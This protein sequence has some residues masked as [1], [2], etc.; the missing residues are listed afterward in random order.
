VKPNSN[1]QPQSSDTG[2]V[3]FWQ[4]VPV[5][6]RAIVLGFVVFESGVFVWAAIL[7]PLLPTP[8]SVLAMGGV[9]WVYW[10]YLSGSWWPETTREIR[11]KRFRAIKMPGLVWKWGLVAAAL[12]VVVVQA[13]FV[14]TFRLVEFP[15]ATFT[16][17]YNL[18]GIPTWSAWVLVVMSSLV[19][20]IC[21][22]TGFRGYMQVPLE[23]RYGPAPAI[24]IGSVVFVVTHLHQAWALPV[25]LHLFAMSVMLGVLAYASGSLIP[26]M[27]GHAVMDIFNFSFW[28]SD[29][30]G[31]FDRQT[32][33]EAGIDAHFVVWVLI[34]VASAA[35]FSWTAH[36]TFASRQR[37]SS[38]K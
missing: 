14:V 32:V 22:E 6:I 29:L 37:V 25:L 8:W 21:E 5:L 12:F 33:A 17:D 20:G 9:L 26:G 11:R 34:L 18:D 4:R 38:R 10:K 31:T 30:A 13:G 23:K 3:R 1:V 35:L 2:M 27:I 15:A 28:W 16:A 24:V 36:K 19:A 7:A